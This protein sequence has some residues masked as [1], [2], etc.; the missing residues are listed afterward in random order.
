M[1]DNITTPKS[2]ALDRPVEARDNS[3]RHIV[4]SASQET[5]R[6]FA[7]E[8]QDIRKQG[9]PATPEKLRSTAFAAIDQLFGQAGKLDGKDPASDPE[10]ARFNSEV[11]P[12]AQAVAVGTGNSREIFRDAEARTLLPM[13]ARG[14][15]PQLPLPGG[16]GARGNSDNAPIRPINGSFFS[17]ADLNRLASGGTLEIQV[18]QNG[19]DGRNGRNTPGPRMDMNNSVDKVVSLISR[20]EGKANTINWNDAGHGISVGLQQSNQH[21]GN[22]PELLKAMHKENP[23]KFDAIFGRNAAKMLNENFVRHAHF[24]RNNELGRAMQRAVNDPELQK[25]QLELT[26]EHVR[27]AAEMARQM[28][29]KS[30]MGVALVADLT[31]QFGEGGAMKYLRQARGH[32][33]EED[34]IRAVANSSRHGHSHRAARFNTI[35]SS[36]IV[37]SR[38][39]FQA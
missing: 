28:G 33:S 38:D 14:D 36:G 31:N 13:I 22:L 7:E 30:T 16:T 24:S 3:E 26:R 5:D 25:P 20:N 4:A 2:K 19:R 35:A 17:Q 39:T 23:A 21:R 27:R 6:R 37:S 8:L 11:R 32:H 15:I 10:R 12:N 29:I 34:K 18:G 1:T 9:N